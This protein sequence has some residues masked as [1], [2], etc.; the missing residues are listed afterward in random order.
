MQVPGLANV[1][2]LKVGPFS[3][4]AILSDATSR[5]WGT[6]NWGQLG[7]GKSTDSYTPIDN[8]TTDVAAIAIGSD[9]A[10]ALHRDGTVSCWGG[11]DSGQLGFGTVGT[12]ATFLPTTVPGLTGV[13][14]LSAGGAHTCALGTDTRVRCWGANSV[15]QLGIGTTSAYAISPVAVKSATP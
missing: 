9:H 4:C 13:V 12:T 7:D 6:D 1:A 11:N 15:G 3:S 5:C 14:A 8:G 2:N 10:C